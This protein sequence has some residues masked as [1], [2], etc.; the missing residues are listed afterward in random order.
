MSDVFAREYIKI[1]VELKDKNEYLKYIA[2]LSVDLGIGKEEQGVYQGLLDREKEFET[3]LGD[4]IAIPHT[5]SNFI[6]KPAVIVIKPKTEVF[7]GGDSD[8]G[9]KIILSLLS[10]NE[11]GGNTHLKLLASLSRKLIDEKFKKKLVSTLNKEEI[12]IMLENALNS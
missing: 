11:Q 5:K 10:P 12:F 7:W 6:L 8:E 2:R 1:N 4:G 9:I 3:N